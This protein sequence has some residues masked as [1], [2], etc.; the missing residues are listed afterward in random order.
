M[1]ILAFMILMFVVAVICLRLSSN[2]EGHGHFIFWAGIVLI[3][4]ALLIGISQAK[5]ILDAQ[6]K[7]PYS[8][9]LEPN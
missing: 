9:M 1:G 8:T 6:D 3:V 4:V 5:E 2:M 7:R